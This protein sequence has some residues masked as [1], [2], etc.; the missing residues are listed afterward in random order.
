MELEYQTHKIIKLCRSFGCDGDV[1]NTSTE[2]TGVT[3]VRPALPTTP[4][5]W[6]P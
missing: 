3:S 5:R 6:H 2:S 4:T 1:P